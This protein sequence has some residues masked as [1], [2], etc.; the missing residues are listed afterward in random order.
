MQSSRGMCVKLKY[1]LS[2][3][4]LALLKNLWLVKNPCMK[5]KPTSPQKCSLLCKAYLCTFQKP[6]MFDIVIETT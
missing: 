6:L 3:S 5:K 2:N 1:Y 4:S